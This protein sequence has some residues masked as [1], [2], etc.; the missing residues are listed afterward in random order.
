MRGSN[1][2]TLR[3]INMHELYLQTYMLRVLLNVAVNVTVESS[4]ESTVE[5]S[6][7]LYVLDE[8]VKL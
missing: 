2:K 7:V 8:R 3:G 5:S 6:C 1:Y 4:V